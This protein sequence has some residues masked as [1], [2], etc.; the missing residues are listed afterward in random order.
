MTIT[1]FED[2][3]GQYIDK[4][5]ITGEVEKT[6]VYFYME[7]LVYVLYHIPDCCE[8][9]ELIDICGDT[10]DFDNATICRAE[11]NEQENETVDGSET[12]SFY[13]LDSDKGSIVLRWKGES[14]GYYSESVDFEA[15]CPTDNTG[16]GLPEFREYEKIVL[17]GKGREH[18]LPQIKEALYK[19]QLEYLSK[20]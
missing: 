19:K 3:K 8:S 6:K 2:L 17:H 14:N 12:Y 20:A 4:L 5:V 11:C 7:D 16:Y 13:R 9:V 18:E 1:E 10:A 15:A